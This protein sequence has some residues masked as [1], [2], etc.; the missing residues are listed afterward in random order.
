MNAIAVGVLVRIPNAAALVEERAG[1]FVGVPYGTITKLVDENGG[2][3]LLSDPTGETTERWVRVSSL[4]FV[5]DVV[6]PGQLWERHDPDLSDAYCSR[7]IHVFRP[8]PGAKWKTRAEFVIEIDD[9]T[10]RVVDEAEFFAHHSRRWQGPDYEREA[11][12]TLGE[13][14]RDQPADDDE[15]I[16][17]CGALRALL[18]RRPRSR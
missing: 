12:E 6:E 2:L 5:A 3:A 9:G 15:I 18:R 10:A 17:S 11:D 1:G 4:E 16:L 13:L 7:I 8:P 14:E